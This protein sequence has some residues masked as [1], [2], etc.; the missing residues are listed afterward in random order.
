L[1]VSSPLS[2]IKKAFSIVL[3]V[4]FT[5]FNIGSALAHTRILTLLFGLAYLVSPAQAIQPVVLGSSV[6]TVANRYVPSSSS[7]LQTI[8]ALSDV[9]GVQLA[10][11]GQLLAAAPLLQ[12][13]KTAMP[14]NALYQLH[15]GIVEE[16][17]GQTLVAKEAYLKAT[18]LDPF[19][20]QAIYNLG[21]LFDKQGDTTQALAYLNKALA[22]KPYSA[23]LHYDIGVLYAKQGR[24]AQSAKH[25]QQALTL[26]KPFC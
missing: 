12:R 21:L 15:Y 1:C 17:L 6:A 19:L 13:A 2:S 24:Y 4:S 26:G 22:L 14:T 18:Q 3:S 16:S 9:L 10:A 23:L 11:Q 25:N 5:T 20:L 7:S 8:A